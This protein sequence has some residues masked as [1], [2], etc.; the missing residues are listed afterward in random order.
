MRVKFYNSKS[1][2]LIQSYIG[3]KYLIHSIFPG[4]KLRRDTDGNERGRMEEKKREGERE[5]EENS[6][7]AK[8]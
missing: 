6:V 2:D 7:F 4:N 8:P 3:S 5:R 1:C